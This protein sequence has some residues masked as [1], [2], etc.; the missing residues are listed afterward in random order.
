MIIASLTLF[1]F[2]ARCN[3]DSALALCALGAGVPGR[4]D[5]AA[6][7]RAALWCSRL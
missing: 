1:L 4:N 7:M 5:N 2:V 3:P 6:L